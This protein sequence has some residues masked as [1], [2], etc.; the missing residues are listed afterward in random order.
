MLDLNQKYL[1]EKELIKCLEEIT[2]QEYKQIYDSIAK[3]IKV[4]HI[5]QGKLINNKKYI[6]AK[7][8]KEWAVTRRRWKDIFRGYPGF[9]AIVNAVGV[10]TKLEIGDVIVTGTSIPED[11]ELAKIELAKCQVELSKQKA[12]NE[13]L[14][15]EL[16][17]FRE[18][19]NRKR[20]YGKMGKGIPKK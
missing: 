4:G 9:P 19:S 3:A 5:K 10:V 2:G 6:H 8:F 11:G 16:K 12:L 14:E 1:P 15:E 17:L 7:S 18:K 13:K 20:E